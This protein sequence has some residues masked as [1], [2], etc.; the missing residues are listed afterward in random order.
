VPNGKTDSPGANNTE[1]R[2]VDILISE[3]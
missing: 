1:D 2:R 3:Q